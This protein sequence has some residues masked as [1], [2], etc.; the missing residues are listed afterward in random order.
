MA[1]NRAVAVAE[2]SGPARALAEVEDLERSGALE[3]YQYLH[4]IKADLLHREGRTREAAAA[5][6]RAL[7][8]TRN[9]A[10]RAFL[11]ERAGVAPA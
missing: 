9:D 10:E 11:A 3:S 4:A 5:Y 7:E 6:R 1:V 8:L 2:V